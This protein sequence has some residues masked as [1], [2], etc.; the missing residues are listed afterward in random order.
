[1]DASKS[2]LLKPEKLIGSAVRGALQPDHLENWAIYDRFAL[3]IQRSAMTTSSD[4]IIPAWYTN[5]PPMI[6]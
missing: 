6:R 3:G 2:T 4:R 1:M 5:P